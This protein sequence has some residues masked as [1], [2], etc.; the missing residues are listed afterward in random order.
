[1]KL[2]SPGGT[3]HTER[4]RRQVSRHGGLGC[5]GHRHR[6]RKPL[7]RADWERETGFECRAS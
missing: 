7:H 6:E 5:A 3:E 4:V 2:V 1:M